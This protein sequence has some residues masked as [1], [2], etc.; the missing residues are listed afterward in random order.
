MGLGVL[1]K[2]S[3]QVI[4][5]STHLTKKSG[6]D[7]KSVFHSRDMNFIQQHQGAQGV[8]GVTVDKSSSPQAR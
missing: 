2:K 1:L 5:K 7:V 4:L 6:Y 3:S 8:T